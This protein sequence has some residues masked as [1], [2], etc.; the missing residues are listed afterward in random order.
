[1]KTNLTP[2]QLKSLSLAIKEAGG[3]LFTNESSDPSHNAQRNLVG[4]THYV[5]ADTL[6]WH[7]S[8]VLSTAI[9]ADGLLFRITESCALDMHNTSR[10]KRC[11]V[12]DVFGTVVNRADLEHTF[13]T[14]DAARN[15]SNK[16]EIDLVAH[17][18]EALK[19]KIHWLRSGLEKMESALVMLA[20]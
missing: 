2:E 3:R 14:S 4:R 15:A 6:K 13:K 7:K 19:S 16:E 1:M 12:F 20:K 8:R 17:Y 5:D 11:V 18:T 10:G 9:L